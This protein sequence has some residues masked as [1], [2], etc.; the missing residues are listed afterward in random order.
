MAKNDQRSTQAHVSWNNR[1]RPKT[2]SVNPKDASSKLQSIGDWNSADSVAAKLTKAS[3]M[4]LD[5]VAWH[6]K[7]KEE[8]VHC[9]DMMSQTVS[10]AMM[11]PAAEDRPPDVYIAGNLE[12]SFQLDETKNGILGILNTHLHGLYEDVYV[13]NPKAKTFGKAGDSHNHAEMQLAKWAQTNGLKVEALGVSKPPRCACNI[14]LRNVFDETSK[15]PSTKAF[16]EATNYHAIL[17]DVPVVSGKGSERC[18]SKVNE[19][20]EEHW[21]GSQYAILDKTNNLDLN[22]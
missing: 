5:R 10:I 12:H 17:Q 15:D 3:I 6:G 9:P 11:K 22:K 8:I 19:R 1:C 14:V 16:Y 4:I 21:C 13:M 20:K 18:E 7:K 2:V